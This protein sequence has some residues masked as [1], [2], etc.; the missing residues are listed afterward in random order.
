MKGKRSV[1]CSSVKRGFSHGKMAT[2]LYANENYPVEREQLMVL[3][4]KG[5][6]AGAMSLT[7]QR[8]WDPKVEYMGSGGWM[9]CWE[10]YFC[11]LNETGS[12]VIS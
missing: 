4:E 5:T 6:L 10:T 9:W 2:G 12:N 7:S 8:G 1:G 11:F 3:E